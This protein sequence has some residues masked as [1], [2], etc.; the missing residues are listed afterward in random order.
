M[1]III[2]KNG[3][4]IKK[5]YQAQ[6]DLKIDIPIEIREYL[7]EFLQNSITNKKTFNYYSGIDLLEAIETKNYNMI[8]EIANNNLLICS[9][10][11]ESNTSRQLPISYNLELCKLAFRIAAS[12]TAN[13]HRQVILY[14]SLNEHTIDLIDILLMMNNKI[15]PTKYIN[16]LLIYNSKYAKFILQQ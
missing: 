9:F 2:R 13:T 14:N 5:T 10:F 16:E 6:L 7:I 3:Y 8:L 12:N 1:R 11:I 15:L 4:L